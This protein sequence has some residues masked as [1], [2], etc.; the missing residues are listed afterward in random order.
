MKKLYITIS[1]ILI[2]S[3]LS[4]QT[5][6]TTEADKLYQRYEFVAA[7]KAYLKLVEKKEANTVEYKQLGN[8]YYNIFNP[9]EAVK[10]YAKAIKKTQHPEIYHRYAQMLKAVGNFEEADKQ[11]DQFAILKPNDF[12]AIQFKNE[13]NYLERL[14]NQDKMFD[15]KDFEMNSNRSDFGA[16]LYD[17]TLYLA[18]A[19]KDSGRKF[20]WNNEPYLEIY[21]LTYNPDG[22]FGTPVLVNELNS[23]YNDGPLAVSADGNTVY[24]ASESLTENV[25][26]NDKAKK[27]KYG[28]VSLYRG[29]K[30][31]GKWEKI[32]SLPFNS[33][34]YNTSN[35]SLS[36][37]G[38]TLYFSSNMPGSIGNVDI[39]KVAIAEDGSFGKPENLGPQINTEGRESF[40]YI[41]DDNK[42]YFSS[43]SHTGFGCYDIFVTDLDKIEVKNLGKPVNSEKDDFAFTYNKDK[44]I[45][46]FASNRGGHDDIYIINKL[47]KINLIATITDAKTGAIIPE[48]TVSIL[49]NSLSILEKT[50]PPEGKI[51]QIIIPEN[52]YEIH[53]SKPGYTTKNEII[54]I[55]DEDVINIDIKLDPIEPTITDV[56]IILQDIYFEYNKSNITHQGANELNKLVKVLNKY[57]N[58]EIFAKSHTDKR[59]S[60]QYNQTLSERRAKSTAQ[61]IIS[62]GIDSKRISAKGFGESEPKINCIH[63]TQ[64]EHAKNRRS[65]FMIVKK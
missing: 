33:K 58:M 8:C 42:L 29:T 40:P 9:T 18:S 14:N 63:C 56:E 41:S 19:R 39:W 34:K 35:P 25:F 31:N 48:A 54:T 47:R 52:N 44:K 51:T 2:N 28:R 38:K 30:K 23:K 43:D 22:T 55:T 21:N 20:A 13:P 10:W 53:L 61:Y 59:G 60:D 46:F 57:P 7:A 1:F 45:G 36:K 16:V 26:Y 49:E 37:D 12:R 32:V 15:I 64:A 24:F 27:T 50:T 17:N 62:K 6:K 11:M 3:I 65:E 4:A 5:K